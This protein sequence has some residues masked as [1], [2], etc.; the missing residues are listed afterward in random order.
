MNPTIHIPLPDGRIG[1]IAIQIRESL[2]ASPLDVIPQ[3]R[4]ANLPE[5]VEIIRH[6][7]ATPIGQISNPAD[8][9]S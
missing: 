9:T 3:P 5:A 6:L 1:Y 4:P 7:A 2:D 8:L